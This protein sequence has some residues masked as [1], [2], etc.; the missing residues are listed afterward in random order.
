M[1]CEKKEQIMSILP[2]KIKGILL[3][4]GLNFEKLQEIR[5]REKQPLCVCYE[6]KETMFPHQITGNELRETLDYIS[7]Y[8]MYAYEQELQ[9]GFITI[10]GGH[11]VG[12]SGKVIKEGNQI[13]NFQYISSI[14]IRVC[15]EIKGCADRI[16]PAIL[17]K[18]EVCHTMII[19]PPGCGKTTLLRDLIRQ[20]SDG[21]QYLSGVNVGVVDE[22]SEI[23]GCY[24][25]VP[26][27]HLG[28]R[29]DILDNC[30]KAEGMMLLIRSMSPKVLAVDEIGTRQDMEAISYAIHC[31]VTII[32]TVHGNDMDEIKEKPCLRKLIESRFFKRYIVLQ[33]GK[34]I[35]EIK[36][37]YNERGMEMCLEKS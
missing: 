3:N 11:R 33:K 37:I 35:G 15:H 28:K 34:R 1:R 21:N 23:G 36:G 26:Q 19:S 6:G 9:Q 2:V 32:T 13:K 17:E 31:G 16:F 4:Q 8:S 22:R 25:G 5:M 10:E 18:N 12:I 30:P 24:Q 27:N 7:H 20:I 14:N 29:T